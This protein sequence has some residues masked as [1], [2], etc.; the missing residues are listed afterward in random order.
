[1]I[2]A[3]ESAISVSDF[4]RRLLGQPARLP[5]FLRG[6]L[7]FASLWSWNEDRRLL[8]RLDLDLREAVFRLSADRG[9]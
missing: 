1:V 7:D 3:G 8:G 5:Q 9:A 6:L 4:A 2:F